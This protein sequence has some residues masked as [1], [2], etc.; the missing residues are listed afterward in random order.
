[1]SVPNGGSLEE[2][3]PRGSVASR[4]AGATGLERAIANVVEETI[5]RTVES[6]AVVQ[7]IE[8]IIEDGR[9]QE[10]VERSID[11][12]QLEEAIKRALDSEVAD[13]VWD[14]ILASDKAQKLV[15]RVAEAPEVRVAIAQQGFS[16]ITDIGRQ[17]SRITEALDD[18]AERLAHA[19]VRS[20]EHEAETNQAGL[21]TR[22]AAFAIDIALLSLFF[23][24]TSGLLA[25]IL[26]AVFGDRTDGLSAAAVAVLFT[27]GLLFGG[28]VFVTFWSLIG[29]TPGMRFLGIRL[30]VAEDGSREIG[31]RRSLKRVLA[32]PFAVIPFGI[33]ILAIL[34][35]PRRHA[36]QDYVAGTEVIYDESS[37]PWSLAPREWVH[38]EG[39]AGERG[40]EQG[41]S[42]QS[43]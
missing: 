6:D 15:E 10:A 11:Q 7:A 23:S 38:L 24:V 40:P 5:V 41:A 8:R 13:R 2:P 25:S 28:G 32:I 26:P 43:G 3:D 39:E 36:L 30:I 19:L 21:V 20:K 16:L 42:R 29:Q 18:A 34:F 14:E 35:S 4:L 37:A 22:G 1:M 31:L 17:V 27:A 33:G 9:L 12:K